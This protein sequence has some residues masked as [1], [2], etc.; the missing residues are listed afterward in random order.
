MSDLPAYIADTRVKDGRVEVLIY[1]LDQ[2]KWGRDFYKP[3]SIDPMSQ[4]EALDLASALVRGAQ[5]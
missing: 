1:V 2:D 3:S 4:R 5:A